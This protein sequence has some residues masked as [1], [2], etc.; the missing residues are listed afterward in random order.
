[1]EI[2]IL[3][4]L[5]YHLWIH[6]SAKIAS[7]LIAKTIWSIQNN[8]KKVKLFHDSTLISS[9][10]EIS[11]INSTRWP[12]NDNLK[13]KI[14]SRSHRKFPF[15]FSHAKISKHKSNFIFIW[16]GKIEN[17]FFVIRMLK[18]MTVGEVNF[19]VV[20][21]VDQIHIFRNQIKSS[22][23]RN[24]SFVCLIL[25]QLVFNFFLLS[26]RKEIKKYI[27]DIKCKRFRFHLSPLILKTSDSDRI[28]GESNTSPFI[29]VRIKRF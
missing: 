18:R 20:S 21:V 4:P 16:T 12:E 10:Q 24:W 19:S 27:F 3:H 23:M 29:R 11:K 1:M 26:K 7:L 8:Q 13:A 9:F 2:C 25:T 22:S 6:F 5:I 28:L 17:E 14:L 15:C